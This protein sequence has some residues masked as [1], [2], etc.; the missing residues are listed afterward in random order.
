MEVEFCPRCIA[1]SHLPVRMLSAELTVHAGE[2][3]A[4]A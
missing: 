2:P 3:D 1:Q 4:A